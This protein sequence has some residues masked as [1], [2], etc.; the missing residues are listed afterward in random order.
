MS[1][2]QF[3]TRSTSLLKIMASKDFCRGVEDGRS[4]APWPKGLDIPWNYERGRLF[5]VLHPDVKVKIGRAVNRQ[6]L[7]LGHIAVF[8][9]AII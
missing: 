9:R 2:H 4:G 1:D 3:Q 5:G 6:A 7:T 8:E